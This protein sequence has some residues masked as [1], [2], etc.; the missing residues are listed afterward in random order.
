MSKL[1]I[2]GDRTANEV[3]ETAR[4]GYRDRFASIE[5]VYFEPAKFF[6][7]DAPRIEE[8]CDEVAFC[9]GVANVGVKCSVVE[10]CLNRGWKPFSVVHPSAVIAESA[11]LAAGCY[12]GP[13]A[14][15]S[16][17]AQVAEHCIV[18][19]HA[20][21]GHDCQIGAACAILPGARLSGHVTLGE[22]SMVGSNAF[23]A[24]GVAIGRQCQ[25]DALTYVSR[26]LP[27]RHIISVRAKK[28][29]LRS[30]MRGEG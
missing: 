16:S 8:S 27:E 29:V 30:D 14:V 17:N 2:F 1:V 20:S 7:E 5:K 9:V 18:H 24:A 6:A 13:L 3:L 19:I 11:R 25:I 23:V 28:P 15:I 26:N 22:E 21:V 10:A 12:V 4:L